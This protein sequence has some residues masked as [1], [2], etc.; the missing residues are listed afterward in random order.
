MDYRGSSG[1]GYYLS[2]I[3]LTGLAQSLKLINPIRDGLRTWQQQSIKKWEK[4][5]A[6]R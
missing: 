4:D 1:S 5:H 3:R 2:R 6:D